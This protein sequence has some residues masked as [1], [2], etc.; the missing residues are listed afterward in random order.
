MSIQFQAEVLLGYGECTSPGTPHE[1]RLLHACT[2]GGVALGDLLVNTSASR[3]ALIAL[4]R[5]MQWRQPPIGA[6]LGGSLEGLPLAPWACTA[7]EDR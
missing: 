2:A 6:L 4:S 1:S 7:A 5:V 3:V